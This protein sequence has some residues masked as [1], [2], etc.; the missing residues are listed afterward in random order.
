MQAI[1]HSESCPECVFQLRIA[2]KIP[3]RDAARTT[4]P[5]STSVGAQAGLPGAPARAGKD[6]A[7]ASI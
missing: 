5:G 4:P 2:V 1:Y 7:A 3:A 6:N